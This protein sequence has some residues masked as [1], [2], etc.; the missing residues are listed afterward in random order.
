MQVDSMKETTNMKKLNLPLAILVAAVMA[1]N[2][3]TSATSQT[4]GY[5]NI[6][7]KGSNGG[8][9]VFSFVPVQLSK[10]PAF[11]GAGS[12]T[13][14]VVTLAGS[15]V[16]DVTTLPHY[17]IIQSG[18]GVGYISDVVSSTS[19]TVTTVQD[20]SAYITSG[21]RVAVIPHIR[22]SDLFGDAANLVIGG[23]TSDTADLVYLVGADGSFVPYY[24]KNS[25]PAST[26]GWKNISTGNTENASVYPSES[27]LV[28]RKA[29]TD[30]VALTQ[31]GDVA[32]QS[33]RLAYDPGFT[34][35][36][37][38]F[39]LVLQLNSLT[40]VLE[41]GASADT[42]DIIYVVDSQSGQLSPYYY[43]NAG[44]ASTRGWKD[45]ATGQAAD[46]TM[47][48][49]NGFIVERRAV[50]TAALTQLAP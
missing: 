30:T 33:M 25:G 29:S 27:V 15:T 34:S 28:E 18:T 49:G 31:F 50:T 7:I 38:A 36:A 26:H 43:K 19:T 21:T 37:S 39:P 8:A 41:G 24:Y 35:S 46:T 42:A 3:Q 44:P 5:Q 10:S 23:G 6:P 22:L 45:V 16:G 1:V 20:L 9:S 17:L 40:S 2:A 4:V 13:G 12:A 48:I 32:N 14:V 11:T 47:N